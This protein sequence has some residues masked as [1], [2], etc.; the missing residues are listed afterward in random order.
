MYPRLVRWKNLRSK[1]AKKRIQHQKRLLKGSIEETKARINQLNKETKDKETKDKEKILRGKSTW[2]KFQL[3]K[4]SVANLNSKEQ[5]KIEQRHA[6]KLDS[7]IIA[8]RLKDGISQ[9]P[10]DSITKGML[11]LMWKIEIAQQFFLYEV[12]CA[13]FACVLLYQ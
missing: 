2:M 5:T 8:K 6:K 12:K 1:H 3:V 10:N 4:F 9:N 11:S 13:N 7:L